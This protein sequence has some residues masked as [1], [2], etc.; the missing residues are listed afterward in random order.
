MRC[1]WREVD[2]ARVLGPCW[3]GAGVVIVGEAFV[4]WWRAESECRRA[5][6]LEVTFN[7]ASEKAVFAEL[8]PPDQKHLPL[9]SILLPIF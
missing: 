2:E 1:C 3:A 4:V 8:S 6:K 7:D 5:L 9:P